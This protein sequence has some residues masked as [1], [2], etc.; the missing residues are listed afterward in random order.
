[1]EQGEELGHGYWPTCHN[2][3]DPDHAAYL[4]RYPWAGDHSNSE[5]TNSPIVRDNG[6]PSRSQNVCVSGYPGLTNIPFTE[7]DVEL[8]ALR[9]SEE[10]FDPDYQISDGAVPYVFFGDWGI[11]PI[12]NVAIGRMSTCPMEILQILQSGYKNQTSH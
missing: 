9:V 4:S 6:L 1:M 7:E 3:P 5:Q 8:T 10:V 11:L 12:S 2:Y